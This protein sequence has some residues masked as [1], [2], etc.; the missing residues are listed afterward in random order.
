MMTSLKK[1]QEEYEQSILTPIDFWDHQAQ[2][3]VWR[4]KWDKVLSYDFHKPEVQWFTGG[5]L[6]ITENCIDRHLPSRAHQ[7]A[8]L[9]ESN[10]PAEP[11][12]RI[13]FRS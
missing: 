5:K 3:F 1:Y 2:H 6:N 13:T 12:R 4:R 7:T 9:W 11:S 10:D 8:I